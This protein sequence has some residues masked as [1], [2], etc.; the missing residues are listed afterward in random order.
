MA[1]KTIVYRT[2]E[3]LSLKNSEGDVVEMLDKM[4]NG[5]YS[6]IVK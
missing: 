4:D 1:D 3:G 6:A 5:W 2:L